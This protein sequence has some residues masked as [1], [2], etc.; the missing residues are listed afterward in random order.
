MMKH[1]VPDVHRTLDA[2]L[3]DDNQK[4]VVVEMARGMAKSTKAAV[5]YALYEICTG[6]YD[7][8]QIVSRVGGAN[9][10]STKIMSKIKKELESNDVL[11]H[12]YGIKSAG[13][14]GAEHIEVGR[15]DGRT[16]M[17]YSRGKR[18][19]IRGSRGLVIIDDPQNEDDVKSSVVITRDEDWFFGDVLPV[20][21][22]DQKLVFIGTTISP[23][24]LL[25]KVKGLPGY[26][27]IEI[28]V[29]DPPGSFNSVWPEQYP[30]DFLIQRCAEMGLDRFNAEYRCMP[31]V[32]GN[33]VFTSG[34]FRYYDP[35]SI[36]FERTK[37]DGLFIITAGDGA[38]STKKSADYTALVTIGATMTGRADAYVLDVQQG[39]WSVKQAAEKVMQ[40]RETWQPNV[41]F[42]E[43][44]CNPPNKDAWVEEVLEREMF[45]NVS[46]NLRW[47]KPTTD[48]LNRA[49]LVQSFF[50]EHRVYFDRENKEQ[51]ALINELLMFTGEQTFPDDQVD[52]MVYALLEMKKWD[53][54]P[55]SAGAK[56][57]LPKGQR[58]R[59]TGYI[60]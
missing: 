6:D 8:I 28:P 55:K 23:I 7:D 59:V 60:A 1:P 32:S 20:L 30:R 15:I 39:R 46:T 37:K 33:P 10:T 16:I 43:S 19:S 52:A 18:S 44:I 56:Q 4:R 36:Q 40:I 34:Q 14:W 53:G 41:V 26:L 12:D 29:D 48:K 47:R 57:V 13:A 27:V 11:I 5:M 51:R 54:V 50:N 9:G 25:A 38:Y 21:L 17:V 35:Q 22:P 49:Y 58:N 45:Y 24:S 31:R 2:A 3:Y 42:I